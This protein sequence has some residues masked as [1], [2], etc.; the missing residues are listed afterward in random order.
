LARVV[1][2]QL[3]SN[4]YDFVYCKAFEE[5]L[6][7]N[8]LA[9]FYG[10][11][12]GM[13]CMGTMLA[14]EVASRPLMAA[15]RHPVEWLCFRLPKTFFLM[16]DDGTRGDVVHKAWGRKAKYEFLFWLT[17][18]EHVD[19]PDVDEIGV[20]YSSNYLFCAARVQRWKRQ[21]RVLR[22]AA[23]VARRYSI[24]LDVVFAGHVDDIQYREE[25]DAMANRLGLRPPIF[26]GA[27]SQQEIRDKARA[28]VAHVLCYDISSRGNVFFETASWGCA[29]VSIDHGSLEPFVESGT[30]GFLCSDEIEAADAVH[31]LLRD[32]LV[33]DACIDS[34][35]KRVRSGVDSP[36][37]RYG[38][39][40]DL[41]ERSARQ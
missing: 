13:R 37:V 2:G 7:A 24:I 40:V 22:V 16:T 21:D 25:L 3:R 35:R 10:V 31:R 20:E 4:D 41:I 8:L 9:N 39:E 23:E 19:S 33:R 36:M 34:L 12:V 14:E 38:K 5:G 28:A 27:V 29:V 15:A 11:P 32:P 18:V 26:L 1:N 6:I 17:G 30:D